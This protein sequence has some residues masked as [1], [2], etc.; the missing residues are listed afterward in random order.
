MQALHKIQVTDYM[1]HDTYHILETQDIA[2]AAKAL[3]EHRLPGA[4]VT[5]AQGELI[6]FVSEHD[7]LRQ[8]LQ[9]SYHCDSAAKVSTVMQTQVMSVKPSDSIIE[10]AEMMSGDKPKVYP[11]VEGKKLVGIITRR[12]ILNA[13]LEN[14]QNC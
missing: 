9:S 13:L 8:L 5:N 11:V 10:V 6:G 3:R 12:D 2:Q 7:V 1:S 14:R 4:P